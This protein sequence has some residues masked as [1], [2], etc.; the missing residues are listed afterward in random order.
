MPGGNGFRLLDEVDRRDFEIIFVTSYGHY[1]IPALRYSAID[2]LLKPVDITELKHAVERVA[3]RTKSG[4]RNRSS[5]QALR[6]N[7]AQGAPQKLAIHGINEIRFATLSDIIRL[8]G[9]SNY[10]HIFTASGERY[11][12]SRTLKDYE[13]MLAQMRNF[14]RVH[15]THMVNADHI[16]SYVKTDG[17]Y[18]VMSDGSKVEVSRRK[19]QELI[20]RLG[21]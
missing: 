10:T 9:D 6:S 1:A 5:Y 13:E 18:V 8:E 16:S 17:G 15:K 2:Y 19:K 7:L 20:G 11:H 4:R 21:L 12:S 14:I 3:E